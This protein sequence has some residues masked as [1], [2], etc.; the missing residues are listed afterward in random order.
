M[1]IWKRSSA[2]NITLFSFKFILWRTHTSNEILPKL[3]STL[4]KIFL[5]VNYAHRL[6]N[7]WYASAAKLL[8][9]QKIMC[10]EINSSIL[11]IANKMLPI[12]NINHCRRFG[13]HIFIPIYQYDTV[14]AY[15]S[16]FVL[17][18]QRKWKC[19]GTRAFFAEIKICKI[20]EK[21]FCC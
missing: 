16:L 11:V 10:N 1:K 7:A 20:K 14:N 4:K 19:T 2:P 18:L 3:Q 9:M 6:W 5:I 13:T 12:H 8:W 17:F 21:F 15:F